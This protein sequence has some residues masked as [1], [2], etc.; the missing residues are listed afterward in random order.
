VLRCAP[1][2]SEPSTHHPSPINH[3]IHA[4][5]A[6]THHPSSMPSML[7]ML[8]MPSMP[9]PI[10]HHPSSI[11]SIPSMLLANNECLLPILLEPAGRLLVG[12][13]HGTQSPTS[14]SKPRTYCSIIVLVLHSC[15]AF[16]PMPHPYPPSLSFQSLRH[17]MHTMKV[18][19][20]IGHHIV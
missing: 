11:P 9:S 6:I 18:V 3:A 1:M 13:A 14:F 7:S 5:H 4:I 17:I 10:T 8:S 20:A 12:T 2:P 15:S 19:T 16:I